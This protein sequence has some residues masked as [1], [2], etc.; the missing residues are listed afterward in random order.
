MDVQIQLSIQEIERLSLHTMAKTLLGA[1]KREQAKNRK[2]AAAVQSLPSPRSQIKAAAEKAKQAAAAEKQRQEK[3]NDERSKADKAQRESNDKTLEEQRRAA[4]ELRKAADTPAEPARPRTGPSRKLASGGSSSAVDVPQPEFLPAPTWQS[5]EDTFRGTPVDDVGA[6]RDLVTAAM[7][8]TILC[9]PRPG[10]GVYTWNDLRA[11]PADSADTLADWNEWLQPAKWVDIV[12]GY[13]ENNS[14]FLNLFNN[15][16]NYNNVL[17]VSA[18]TPINDTSR[19]PPQLQQ[20]GVN[21]EG[22]EARELLPASPYVIRMTRTDPF[23][24]GSYRSMKLE[25]LIDETTATL[26]AASTGVGPPVLAATMWPWARQPGETQQRYGLV[27]IIERAD[28][29]LVHWQNELRR[30]HPRPDVVAPVPRGIR[31]AAENAAAF[32]SLLCR[33]IAQMGYINFDIKAGNLLWIQRS[34]TFYMTD[35]DAVYYIRVASDVVG[36]K[37]CFFTNM[38]LLCMHIRSYSSTGFATSFL[39]MVTPLMLDLWKEAVEDP[40]SFG[41][42][43][44][45]LRSARIASKYEQGSFDR[46]ALLRIPSLSQRLA[47]QL[48]MMV[49]EY[50]FDTSD[51]K[52]PPPKALNWSGWKKDSNFVTGFPPLVPQ[53]VRF[54]FL[55]NRPIPD[56]Y[57]SVL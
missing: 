33:Q 4:E 54:A 23:D 7:N 50:I 9:A 28:G 27:M 29:D 49:F 6:L 22:A 8:T 45:F 3:K 21:P 15:R 31:E 44:N 26:H 14:L 52:M 24:N 56:R 12:R 5:I 37:A 55:F 42:G 19:W 43:A 48:S 13:T 46:Q 57:V 2:S 30:M 51:G 35:F 40:E 18:S 1:R 41:A 25:K 32:L 16:G 36:E 39:A 11:P 38:L 17:D 53:L 34:N 20:L 10:T 47:L